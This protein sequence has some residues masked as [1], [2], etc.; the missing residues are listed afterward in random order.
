MDI[1]ARRCD[2]MRELDVDGIVLYDVQDES[3]RTDD[4]RPFPF[5]PTLNPFD[6]AEKL[7]SAT[8]GT[9]APRVIYIATANY[10]QSE[11][12]RRVRT[13]DATCE[14]VVLVG[15]SSSRSRPRVKLSEAYRLLR[16]ERPDVVVGG[17]TIP[18]RHTRRGDEHSRLIEKMKSGCQFFISQCVFDSTA[19]INTLSDCFYETERRDMVMPR[20]ILTFSPCGSMQTLRFMEW[21]GIAIPRWLQNDLEHARDAIEVSLRAAVSAAETIARFCSDH[22]IAF[23]FNVESVSIRK[24]EVD[25]AGEL[26]KRL[27]E[28]L[29]RRGL[30]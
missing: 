11:L 16:Q 19:A 28:V 24:K 29:V 22:S 9:L 7:V 27:I 5:L 18:E 26:T 30:R 3:D 17:V 13:V 4:D 1:A 25:A 8:G 23:G 15:A 6:F 21:L 20:V 14:A 2:R 10:S 12:T